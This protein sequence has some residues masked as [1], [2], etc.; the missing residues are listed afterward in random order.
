MNLSKTFE[1]A[2]FSK[3]ELLTLACAAF[4]STQLSIIITLYTAVCEQPASLAMIICGLSSLQRVPLT[5]CWTTVMLA[6]FLIIERIKYINLSNKS[7]FQF[8]TGL[9]INFGNILRKDLHVKMIIDE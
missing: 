8:C 7:A 2:S 4:S 6:V 9:F 1:G 5:V 3:L